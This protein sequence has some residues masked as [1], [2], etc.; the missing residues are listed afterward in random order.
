[1]QNRNTTDNKIKQIEGNRHANC[2]SH[3]ELPVFIPAL[4]KCIH[5]PDHS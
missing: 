3:P 1:M 2:K 5:A 4:H